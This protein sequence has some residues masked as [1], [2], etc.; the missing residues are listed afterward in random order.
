M[1]RV[2]RF[3]KAVNAG[4][5]QFGGVTTSDLLVDAVR[6]G[7]VTEER[8]DLS[9]ARIL[10][11]KFEQGLFENPYSDPL[12]ARETVGK[13]DFVKKATEAQAK[14]AVLLE[15]RNHALPLS[16]K[17]TRLY[18][19]QIDPAVAT[20]RGFKVVASPAEADVALSV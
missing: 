13:P 11:Q 10:K 14:S 6:E 17:A 12:K 15:N 18:L 19:Y 3:A 2:D 9:A 1:P 8:I 7:K 5:D 20:S 16:K 4:V